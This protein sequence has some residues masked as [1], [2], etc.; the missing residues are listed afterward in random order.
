[1]N[2]STK[3]RFGVLFPI[4]ALIGFQF[5]MVQF[6]R[7]K[8]ES[9]GFASMHVAFVSIVALPALI[10]LNYWTL[11]VRWTRKPALLLGGLALPAFMGTAMAALI[12]GE[13]GL[14]NTAAYILWPFTRL[15]VLALEH[16]WLTW[17]LIIGWIALTVSL[18][19]GARRTERRRQY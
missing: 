7:G 14:R 8:G 10:L 3:F 12:H 19:I 6:A 13:N 1:M 4:L 5:L 11:F 18:F 9:A 17:V 15:L 2:V 16:A